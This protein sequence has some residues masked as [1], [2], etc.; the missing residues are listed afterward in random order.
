MRARFLAILVS[1]ALARFVWPL[2]SSAQISIIPG[3][4]AR[5]AELFRRKGCVACH[6]FDG[7]GG[8][9]APDLAQRN[10]RAHTPMQLAAALW[11]HAPRMWR[12]QQAQQI[13]IMLDS[14]ETADLF[15]YFYSLAYAKAPGNVA[16][17]ARLFQEKYCVTCHETTVGAPDHRRLRLQLPITTWTGVDDPLIWAEQMW[18]HSAKV[19]AELSTVGL[20]WPRFSTDDM[21]DNSA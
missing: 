21:V 11:N 4:S 19:Y 7:I 3:S 6:A 15:A 9:I 10:E 20:S 2:P 16:R 8:K 14:A 5:G 1:L 17:G 12:A 13:K 18:N